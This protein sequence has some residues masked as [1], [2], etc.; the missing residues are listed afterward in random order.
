MNYKPNNHQWTEMFDPQSRIKFQSH[1]YF[2]WHRCK[3]EKG[4]SR[5]HVQHHYG[6][7][8]ICRTLPVTRVCINTFKF[9]SG[10]LL[11][12]SPK[13]VG[14]N[15]AICLHL[16]YTYMYIHQLPYIYMRYILHMLP[17]Y[18]IYTHV[19]IWILACPKNG[20]PKTLMVFISQTST[21]DG[22]V[23]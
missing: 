2:N 17:M 1:K 16:V 21:L 6:H 3:P 14:N 10:N 15:I 19:L 5:T 9:N 7:N 12:Q 22:K 13:I 18:Y 20:A 4:F 8:C 11:K 23:V